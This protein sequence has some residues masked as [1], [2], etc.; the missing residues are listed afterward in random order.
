MTRFAIL[1]D[2]HG[3]AAAL[4]AVRDRGPRLGPGLRRRRRRPRPER[5]GAGRGHRSSCARWRRPARSSCR[6]TPTSRSPTSTTRRRSR[7]WPTACRRPSR[8]PP[9][10]PTTR[11]ATTGSTGCAGCPPSVG[12]APTTARWSSSAT[13]S[14]GSQTAGFDQTLDPNVIVER[15]SRTDARVIGCGHTHLPEIRDLGWKIIVNAGSVG[16][17]FD[18]EATASWALVDIH[19]GEV[20]AEIRRT[21]YDVLAVANAISARG[22]PGDVYRA[23]HGPDREARPM[24]EPRRVVVTGMGMVTA[25]GN[26]VAVHLGRTR[27]R[28]VRRPGDLHL[29][30]EPPHVADRRRGRRLRF[31]RRPRSQ[32]PAPDGPLHPVRARRRPR[33]ARPGRAARIASR[34]SSPSGPGWSSGPGLGGVG[35]LVDGISINAL[36]G[37]DRISPFL[38]PMGI[39]NVGAGQV[40]INFGMTGP[41]FATVSACATGGHALGESSEII[42]R[43]DADIM[44]AGGTEAGIFEPLVGGFAAMRALSTR[45]D[46]PAAASRPFDA[47]RDGFV[48]AEGSGVLVLEELRHAEAR[49]AT[50]LGGTHRLRRDRRCLAHHAAR[51]RWHGRRAGRSTGDG[52]GRRR[53][54]GHRPPQCPCDLD[55]RRRQGRAAGDPDDLR[56]ATR[57]ASS[58]TRQQVDARATPSGRPARSRPSPRSR[59]C[60]T[61]ASRRRSTSTT[62]TRPPRAST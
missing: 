3:N 50:I 7:G 57:R 25:L 61:R 54:R 53:A 28:P 33:G 20:T 19:D 55:A 4:E 8:R 10:G 62:R 48:V 27:R 60:A 47:G 13:R 51:P 40:A 12:C 41:N 26:D 35:T 59:R 2:V 16:Y 37:P 58:V 21:E 52:E 5:P 22:L 18:G 32:G 30:C 45:N 11:W 34:A 1:S 42:R 15:I 14:P 6:A 31:E 29:R 9:N 24:T 43:G 39:P 56:R 17:I 36:R 38:I 23:A 46:D 44:L 49:G